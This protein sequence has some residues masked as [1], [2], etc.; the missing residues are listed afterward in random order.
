M[1]VTPIDLFASFIRLDQGGRVRAERPVFDSEWGGWQVMTFH[2]ET[3]ADVHGD[4]WEVHP[5]A[6]EVVA[7]L[8]GG[9]RLYFRPEEPGEEEAEV[10]VAAGAAVIVPRG[11]RH[12]IALD[13]PSDIMS[14]TMPR[15]SRLERRA[16]A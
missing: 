5:D 12:R 4:H 10:K 16:E 3:D 9:I 2:V 11:R 7:C 1:T 14:V 8:A 13:G 15:G 6:E